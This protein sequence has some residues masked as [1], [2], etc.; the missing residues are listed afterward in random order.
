MLTH[1]RNSDELLMTECCPEKILT[2][3]SLHARWQLLLG[4]S[5]AA[6]ASTNS[7]ARPT[8]PAASGRAC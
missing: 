3:S 1:M 6:A 4:S 8:E 7:A 2:I 5:A